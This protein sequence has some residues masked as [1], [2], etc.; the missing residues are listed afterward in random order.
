MDSETDSPVFWA[1]SLVRCISNFPMGQKLK[2]VDIQPQTAKQNWLRFF[3]SKLHRARRGMH[4]NYFLKPDDL[5]AEGPLTGAVHDE[6]VIEALTFLMRRIGGAYI[7]IGA[8][9]GMMALA[10]NGLCERIECVEPNP[11]IANVLRT[12]LHLHSTN[13]RVHEFALGP[14]AGQFQLF[15]PKG[16]M[17]GAFIRDA[18]LYTEGMLAAKDGYENFSEVNYSIHSIPVLSIGEGLD[19]IAAPGLSKAVIKID[20]EG[21]EPMIVDGIVSRYQALFEANAVAVVFECHERQLLEKIS[22]Q[23]A[24]FGFGVFAIATRVVMPSKWRLL[25]SFI[26]YTKGAKRTLEFVRY[27]EVGAIGTNYVIC[28]IAL[29]G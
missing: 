28:P 12:N 26:R 20:V 27:D 24:P 8:N 23:V 10:V 18:N 5:I 15:V 19:I 13:F 11:L 9:I 2:T 6:E 29:M 7:D 21:F 25:N 3:A 4:P 17:G 16:N 1:A 14:T 22:R